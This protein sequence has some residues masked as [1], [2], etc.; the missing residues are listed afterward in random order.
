[1]KI[2]SIHQS[3][4]AKQG[5]CCT[6]NSTVITKVGIEQ[7]V[8]DLPVKQL[9]VEGANCGGCVQSIEKALQSLNG[10]SNASMDLASSVVSVCGIVQTDELI[11][12][13][14]KAGYPAT[15]LD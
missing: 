8:S 14:E 10:V 3:E 2:H 6:N 4:T 15:V 1:M 5:C 12:T 9:K 13:L 7:L 11:A